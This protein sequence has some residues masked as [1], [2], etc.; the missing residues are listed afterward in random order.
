[1]EALPGYEAQLPNEP[2]DVMADRVALGRLVV[3]VGE[4]VRDRLGRSVR[5]VPVHGY[6]DTQLVLACLPDAHS[7]ASRLAA[8][9]HAVRA[10]YEPR[11]S[12]SR[13]ADL[14]GTRPYADGSQQEAQRAAASVGGETK[15]V[16]QPA[17]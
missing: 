14:A 11:P 8:I 6:P 17:V 10:G 3:V 15:P 2:L 12:A 5:T 13:S 4:S 16:G 9:A 7:A 1:M